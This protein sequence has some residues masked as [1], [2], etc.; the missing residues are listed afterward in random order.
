MQALQPLLERRALVVG[1]ESVGVE[2]D[3]AQLAAPAHQDVVVARFFVTLLVV[4][5]IVLV[6][7][8]AEQRVAHD[9]AVINPA[10]QSAITV[11]CVHLSV[12]YE[13]LEVSVDI[14][15]HYQFYAN[16]RVV[17]KLVCMTKKTAA[18]VTLRTIVPNRPVLAIDAAEHASSICNGRT[19]AVD[20]RPFLL[21]MF[22]NLRAVA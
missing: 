6:G 5:V 15:S 19:A 10:Q 9:T 20:T 1:A 3:K 18:V 21:V 12:V 22:T 8:N 16:P 4:S 14:L 13:I 7:L 11:C 2:S 17:R